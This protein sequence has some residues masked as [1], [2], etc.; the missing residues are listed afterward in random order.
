MGVTQKFEIS[1]SATIG[2][3]QPT[4]S[5]FPATTGE[6]ALDASGTYAENRLS[7]F[8]VNSPSP[9]FQDLLAGMSISAVRG[10]A[11]R[12]QNGILTVR[13]TTPAGADQVFTVSD[14]L[15]LHCPVKGSE[16]TKLAAQGS[17]NVELLISGDT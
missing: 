4:A 11:L 10:L 1:G 8:S 14:V 9:A 6:F 13:V 7:A 16:L 12:V 15:V 3:L 5:P 2:P 17:A